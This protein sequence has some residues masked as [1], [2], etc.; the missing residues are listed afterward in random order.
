MSTPRASC[1][2]CSK[3][4]T[5]RDKL[6]SARHSCD[7]FSQLKE[8]SS[9]MEISEIALLPD[10]PAPVSKDAAL[11]LKVDSGKEPTYEDV[12]ELDA[13]D[14]K[15]DFV[16][17]AMQQA[18]DPNTNSVRDLKVDDSELALAKN[19][20]HFCTDIAGKSIK[21]PF[22][23]QLWIAAN[24]L[25][26]YCPKCTNP[27]W[28][29]INNVPVDMD[30][31][32]LAKKLVLTVG[33]QC[34]KCGLSRAKAILTKQLIDYNQLVLV[35]G[36]RAGKSAF[37][38]TINGYHTHRILKSPKLS[39]ICRGIQDFTPLTGTF[40]A[41]S[42]GRAIKLLWNPFSTMI[43]AS[44]WFSSYFEM[45]DMNG[46]KYGKEFYKRRDLFIRFFHKNLD[47]YPMG[48]MKR[49]L[50]GDTRLIASTDEIGW[51][52][53]KDVSTDVDEDGDAIED[54][55]DDEREMAN[56]DEVHQSLDNSLSTIRTEVYQ[57][58]KRDIST[59]PTGLNLNISSPQSWKD[60]ICRLLKESADPA[61]L[62]L[63]VHLP[64]WEIN[65][66]YS[67]DHP[68]ILSAYAKNP[69]RAERDFGANPPRLSENMFVKAAL[70]ESFKGK[71]HHA[72]VYDETD[73]GKTVGKIIDLVVKAS[74]DP[75]VI[76]L[77]AGL[78]NNS[79]ALALGTRNDV[80]VQLQSTLELIPK[81][82][83]PISFPRLYQQVLL[84]LVKNCNVVYVGADRWNSV[85]LLQQIEEDTKGRTKWMHLTLQEHQFRAFK[86]LVNSGEV[87]L[88][89]LDATWSF[90]RIEE[91]RN[92]RTELRSKPVEHLYLQFITAQLKNGAINKGEG[93]TDDLL[94]ALI[95]MTTL[96]FTPKVRKYVL[97]CKPVARDGLSSRAI[98]IVSG[99]S[100]FIANSVFR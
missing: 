87:S 97:E 20:F 64:T 50:R 57:L 47:Y 69:R 85:N 1:L 79:F 73:P 16:W 71:Q 41:L 88:P 29:D 72:I 51:F 9:I 80:G 43:T 6:K 25:G 5:C 48:P 35:A 58:Y 75:S 8:V 19:Y 24:L 77:D 66:L 83:S 70:Q 33:G 95:V 28:L 56:G 31:N 81:A 76:G 39:S 2:K 32:Y 94:R 89:A 3:Y 63:G 13:D 40:V 99:T 53:Y 65:P 38:A 45:L 36:Q 22:S 17:T 59:I 91:V 18:F 62:S 12:Q 26:E 21:I 7:S 46:R 44:E 82:S 52:P 42:T 92:Y 61:A 34:P 98:S 90:D 93:Y 37:T 78:V 27:K 74:W 15:G 55:S 49:T 54:G 100:N 30:S 23:R 96:H 86:E 84:P 10:K 67:R 60:K 68:I 4:L 11:W 14:L